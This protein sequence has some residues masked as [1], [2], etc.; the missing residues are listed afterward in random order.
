MATTAYV[1][2]DARIEIAG[3]PYSSQANEVQIPISLVKHDIT[4]FGGVT[5][6]YAPGL[7]EYQPKIRFMNDYTDNA[8][9]EVILGLI[10][11]RSAAAF[12]IRL[13]TASIGAANPEAQ[14]SAFPESWNPLAGKVGDLIVSELALAPTTAIT[15]AISA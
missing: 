7:I 9:N 4:A 3:T 15:W 2:T 1:L 13:T 10:L 8:L 14:F 5:R 12:K 6:V 11:G